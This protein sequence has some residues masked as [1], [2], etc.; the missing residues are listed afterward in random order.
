MHV[1]GRHITPALSHSCSQIR[2]S[3]SL[4][5]LQNRPGENPAF[6]ALRILWASLHGFHE[7]D[8]NPISHMYTMQ[9]RQ[10]SREPSQVS[11]DVS[12]PDRG[13]GGGGDSISSSSSS[14][15]GRCRRRGGGYGERRLQKS[16]DY[17]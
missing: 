17:V 6:E 7:L 8:V 1:Y 13:H 5:C 16:A 10:S 12:A 11:A 14:R 3:P 4:V 2:L 9:V 15:P